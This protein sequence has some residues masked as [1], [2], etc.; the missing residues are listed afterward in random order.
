MIFA[1]V[2]AKLL[3]IPIDSDLYFDNHV[4][5]IIKKASQKL[6]AMS[7]IADIISKEKKS[8]YIKHIF[9]VAIQLLSFDMDVLQQ[10]CQ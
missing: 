10:N 4:K 6:T 3:G 8:I 1:K 5:M 9:L 2:I 7:R